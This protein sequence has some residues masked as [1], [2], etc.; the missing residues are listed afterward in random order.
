MIEPGENKHKNPGRCTRCGDE[1]LVILDETT[2][3]E[4]LCKPCYMGDPPDYR[5]WSVYRATMNG[6]T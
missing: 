2:D 5:A 1:G 4:R 6:E 3:G